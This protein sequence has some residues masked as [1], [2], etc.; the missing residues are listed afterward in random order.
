VPD[1]GAGHDVA[2]LEVQVEARGVGVL[3]RLVAELDADPGL[4]GALVLRE[5]DVAMDAE[6]RP[7]AGPRV[8]VEVAADTAQPRRELGD[9]LLRRVEQVLLVA[10]PV[11]LEPVAVVVARQV[12][13][14]GKQSRT[15][16]G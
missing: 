4:V 15:E 2:G 16:G 11:G 5:A 8:G 13:Q 1:A 12:A 10:C 7:L 3:G 14:K 6:Q 9:E